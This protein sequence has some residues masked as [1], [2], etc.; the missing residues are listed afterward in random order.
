MGSVG[1]NSMTAP[2]VF[3]R[4]AGTVAAAQE[5]LSRG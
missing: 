1:G 4:I 3:G 2:I 5:R